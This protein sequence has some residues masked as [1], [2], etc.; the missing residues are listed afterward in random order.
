MKFSIKDFFSK[1]NQILSFLRIWSHLP[2]KFLM[3]SDVQDVVLISYVP[4]VY[5][6]YPPRSFRFV[7]NAT[8]VVRMRIPKNTRIMFWCR[9]SGLIA[10]H[11]PLKSAKVEF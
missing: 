1:F 11:T 5:F 10:A 9:L 7:N 6:V 2:K 8:S 3:A 4:S